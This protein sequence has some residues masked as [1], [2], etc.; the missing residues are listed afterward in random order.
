MILNV[1]NGR[2][3]GSRASR[4]GRKE[5]RAHHD[6][7]AAHAPTPWASSRSPPGLFLQSISYLMP[8]ARPVGLFNAWH[9]S[10]GASS[11]Y[12][13]PIIFIFWEENLVE[14]TLLGHNRIRFANGLNQVND[15]YKGN[16]FNFW[17]C[18][19]TD[20]RCFVY[21]LI[22]EFALLAPI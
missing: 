12:F 22:F 19:G 20:V 3:W 21:V 1:R 7:L 2:P 15:Y 9:S 16:P 10:L 4:V 6:S 14:E 5:E 8:Y 11:T 13:I 18:R 17:T